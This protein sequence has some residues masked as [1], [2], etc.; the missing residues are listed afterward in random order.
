MA[1]DHPSPDESVKPLTRFNVRIGAPRP[2]RAGEDSPP[3]DAATSEADAVPPPAEQTG[4]PSAASPDAPSTPIPEREPGEREPASPPTASGGP[5]NAE[6]AVAERAADQHDGAQQPASA[7]TAVDQP[8]A[9]DVPVPAGDE[10]DRE[11]EAALE[12][13]SIESLMESS[14]T[15]GPEIELESRQRATIVR[16]DD[17]YAFFSLGGPHEGLASLRQFDEPPQVGQEM[18]VVVTAHHE[19]DGLYELAVPGASVEVGDWS[20]LVEGAVVEVRITGT[21]TGGLEGKVNNAIRGFIPASQISMHRVENFNEY[22][23]QKLLCVV[24]EVN[25]RRKKLVLS[26][27]AI[28]EREREAE[29]K[30]KLESLE[31]GQVVEGV[32]RSI[33]D[34]GAFVDLGGLDG[35]IHVSQLSWERV[36]HPSDVLEEGQKVRVK[37]EK[38]DQQTGKIGLSLKAM[39]EH[40]WARVEERFP[41][42]STVH[43]VVSRIAE[44]GAFVKLAPGVEGLI[45]ISELAHQ[46]VANV[47]S[48]LQEGQE[49]DCK[50]L[51][52]D[53][54]KQRIS[55]SLKAL[56]APPQPAEGETPV[57]EQRTP[58][59]AKVPLRGG[60]DHSGGGEQFGLKW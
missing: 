34:F 5:T 11:L 17:E 22:L 42:K 56:Q 30:K 14:T 29:R 28:L 53:R 38:L 46:R 35:L 44:F 60:I 48:V 3:A 10:V 18:E 19:D 50:V 47:S 1:D 36:K 9:G 23:E 25:P 21:N 45:H 2:K 57:A 7:A 27:R 16:L 15:A 31:L 51:S 41:P 37:I 8:P 33:R 58:L 6:E 26:H 4:G 24:M 52:V 13:A 54:E 59:K 20:D 39:S 12:G 55:L 32:V 40:P 49:I 43:G